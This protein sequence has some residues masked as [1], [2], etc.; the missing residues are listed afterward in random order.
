MG[1]SMNHNKAYSL[2]TA[3]PSITDERVCDAIQAS[4]ESFVSFCTRFAARKPGQDNFLAVFLENRGNFFVPVGILVESIRGDRILG[5]RVSNRLEPLDDGPASCE[6]RDII[7]WRYIDTY[8]MEGGALYRKIFSLQ[9]ERVQTTIRDVLPFLISRESEDPGE[10]RDVFRSI[11][12]HDVSVVRDLISR[13]IEPANLLSRM[14]VRCFGRAR[15]V[16][17]VD[18]SIPEYAAM[19]GDAATIDILHQNGC[20]DEMSG[21]S[22]LLIDA[23]FQGNTQ[24]VQRFLELGYSADAVGMFRE[25]ALFQA[26]KWGHHLIIDCLIRGGADVNF[27]NVREQTPLFHAASAEVAG[28]LIE[29]G[30]DVNASS[31]T[32]ETPLATHWR[33]G[34]WDVVKLLIELGASDQG[35]GGE[36]ASPGLAG[37]RELGVAQLNRSNAEQMLKELDLAMSIDFGFVLPV[38][39]IRC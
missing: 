27:R 9:P 25:T 16:A 19:Y 39:E 17:L 26:V 30:A 32:G 10:L 35:A 14:P 12:H 4:R 18:I 7:D 37:V 36:I 3:C 15:R 28:R 11:A 29:A 8:E 13:G 34:R 31:D 2:P 23:S 24:V 21:R 20:L 1:E 5:R 38:E 33:N 6:R 22:P